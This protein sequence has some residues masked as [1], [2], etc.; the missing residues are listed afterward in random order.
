MD[1][2]T[3]TSEASRVV[4]TFPNERTSQYKNEFKT[5]HAESG[6][7]D[8]EGISMAA[9]TSDTTTAS[10]TAHKRSTLDKPT[11]DTVTAGELLEP[12]TDESVQQDAADAQQLDRIQ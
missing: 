10:P 4:I 8:L 7:F 5:K 2:F 3:T 11:E 9:S 1:N 12:F 6:V